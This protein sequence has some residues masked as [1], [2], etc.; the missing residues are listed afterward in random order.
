MNEPSS[1]QE[2]IGR[3]DS[4]TP[5][6]TGMALIKLSGSQRQKQDMKAT[7]GPS[8]RRGGE[9]LVGTEYVIHICETVKEQDS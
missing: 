2:A 6:P 7:G 5:T 3:E 9:K 8:G 1:S 4:Y